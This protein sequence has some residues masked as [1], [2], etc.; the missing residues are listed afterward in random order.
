LE[1]G[2][3][4]GSYVSVAAGGGFLRLATHLRPWNEAERQFSME[5]YDVVVV[6]PHALEE[7]RR[8][9]TP[10]K[11]GSFYEQRELTRNGNHRKCHIGD[12]F[13]ECGAARGGTESDWSQRHS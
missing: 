5:G 4:G 7:A 9:L 8:T 12:G 11:I 10:A 6:S 1:H 2:A 3:F 13:E